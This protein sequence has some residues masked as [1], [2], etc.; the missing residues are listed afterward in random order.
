LSPPEI[1]GACKKSAS[2][3][4]E[5][6]KKA[7]T[8]ISALTCFGEPEVRPMTRKAACLRLLAE[9][10]AN[11]FFNMRLRYASRDLLQAM[12]HI[13]RKSWCAGKSVGLGQILTSS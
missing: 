10:V 2:E 6:S 5:K 9:D 8:T 13:P 11:G 12:G 4:N 3:V 1:N 7:A